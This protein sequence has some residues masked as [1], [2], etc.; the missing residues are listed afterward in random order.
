MLIIQ[1]IYT[2]LLQQET[3]RKRTEYEWSLVNQLE[4]ALSD[5]E[6][7]LSEVKRDRDKLEEQANRKNEIENKLKAEM[8]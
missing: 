2:Y 4:L 6:E 1:K 7:A 3:N 8:E 5:I